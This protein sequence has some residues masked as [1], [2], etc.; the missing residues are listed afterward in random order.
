[1]IWADLAAAA[2]AFW[3][4]ILLLPWQPW[5][6]RETLDAEPAASFPDLTDLT[7]LIPARNEAPVI[8]QTLLALKGQGEG[9]W[10]VLIDDQSNDGTA[11]AAARASNENLEI[12]LGEAPPEGWNGKLWALEQG[13]N[14]ANTPY[15]MLLDA[16][17][18][19]EPGTIAALRDKMN[20]GQL[21]FVSLMA[22]LR[23]TGLWEVLLMP[24]FVY[25]FKLLYPFA[26]SNARFA[27]IAAG[28]GGCVLLQTAAL[29]QIGG[30]GAVKGALIDDCALAKAV[31]RA[32]FRTWIGLTHS[33]VSLRPYPRLA[34]IWNMV[35]RNAF[36]QLHYSTALLVLVTLIFVVGCAIPPLALFVFPGLAATVLGAA[37]IAAMSVSY[38]PTLRYYGLSPLIGLLFPLIGAVY[39]TMTW[40]S[41]TRYWRGQRSHWKGRSYNRD[42]GK[43]F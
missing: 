15:I 2:A 27:P 17:I 24:A 28:A 12:I 5:R 26:L 10:I 29:E 18:R 40:S 20:Q 4:L 8:G 14:R 35:A 23:M 31:K 9:L 13:R 1:M 42:D 3:V 38:A 43:P 21:G 19:L 39:L 6:T 7:I 36:T 37:A 32:G 41:A 11:A 22:R 25:F 16:D 33:A 34:N 30:F